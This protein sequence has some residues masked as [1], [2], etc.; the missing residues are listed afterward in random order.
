MKKLLVTV[1]TVCLC[2]IA[3]P[4]MS[5]LAAD[6]EPSNVTIT[7]VMPEQATPEPAEEPT[8]E[9]AA[10]AA[11][12]ITIFPVDVAEV[13]D[14]GNWQIIRTYE[15]LPG[16][17]PTDIPQGSFERSGWRFTLTDIIR[18]ESSNAETREHTET[19][20][21]DT[22]TNELEQILSLLSNTMEYRSEDGFVGILTL[23]VSSIKVET[24]GTKTTSHTMT[25]TR[26][27]PN[28]SSN[29]TSLVPK[30]VEDRGKTY[31]LSNV[32]WRVG[33]YSTVDY[34]RIP[35]YYTAVATFTATGYSTKVTGYVT[36]AEY[37]GT[38]GK[39]SQGKTTYI[40]YFLGEEI[41]T[42]LEMVM[43]TPTPTP[44]A[45]QTPTPTPEP[46]DPPVIAE[47]SIELT[48]EPAC[49]PACA[50]EAEPADMTNDD[51][52]GAEGVV[53]S[54][55]ALFA[56]IPCLAVLAGGALYF[57]KKRKG[58]TDNEKTNNTTTGSD[59]CGDDGGSGSGG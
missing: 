8:P 6:A 47:P 28:L 15:L 53:A 58:K 41:R 46:S 16:E 26:E 5:A 17:S 52:D 14:K 32:D 34:E 48:C 55:A 20:T 35:D 10:P 33:N 45:I 21:L 36:T 9:P 11:E 31:T 25:V 30:T 54:N 42:P 3:A 38:L 27:Y 19:I 12:L 22:E 29:D 1:F 2:L 43:P 7:V 18:K 50:H 24:A 4:A 56:I 23:D 51:E 44:T 57:I 49:N 37:S 13:R 40:A 59:D 39:L